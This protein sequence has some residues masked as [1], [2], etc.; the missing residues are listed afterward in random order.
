[1]ARLKQSKLAERS[2]KVIIGA[3]GAL[4]R[5]SKFS[6]DKLREIINGD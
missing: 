3:Y 5:P 1:M 2:M 4:E 6:E